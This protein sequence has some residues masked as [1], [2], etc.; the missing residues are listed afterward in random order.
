MRGGAADTTGWLIEQCSRAPLLPPR[1]VLELARI[2][3][4]GL[5]PDATA[6]QRRASSRARDKLFRSNLRLVVSVARG[7][8]RRIERSVAMDYADLIQ[9][10]MLGLHRAIEMYD[11]TKGYAFSTYAVWW[12]RQSVNRAI[13]NQSDTIR[14]PNHLREIMNRAR[15]APPGLDRAALVEHCRCSPEALDRALLAAKQKPTSLD[16]HLRDGDGDLLGDLIGA[17]DHTTEDAWFAEDLRQAIEHLRDLHADDIALLELHHLDGFSQGELAA[18]TG[19][20]RCSMAAAVK[21]A[22][23]R[24]QVAGG[25][26]ALAL[27]RQA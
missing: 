4:R 5:E 1:Q 27:L 8:K 7:Y 20:S 23:Q 21:T 2:Y 10:G 13:V 3:R 12:I 25:S 18:A 19:S 22:R 15:H 17:A 6:G 9:E 26:Q 16:Q 14:I 24:L 11:F